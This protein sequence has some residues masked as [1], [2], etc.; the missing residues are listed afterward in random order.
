[1]L[2]PPNTNRARPGSFPSAAYVLRRIQ[3]NRQL[4]AILSILTLFILYKTNW[5]S[6]S[7]SSSYSALEAQAER[8]GYSYDAVNLEPHQKAL[9]RL[10]AKD[11]RDKND[12]GYPVLSPKALRDKQLERLLALGKEQN[13]RNLRGN[14]FSPSSKSHVNCPDYAHYSSSI[15]SPLSNGHLQLPFQRPTEQCRTFSADS[16]EK[17]I[18]DM[19]ARL[20]DPDLARLFENCFPNT[21][22]T[23]VLWH[24]NGSDPQSFIV[25][26]D[27]NALWLRDAH[28]Q[29][30]IYSPLAKSDP[31]IKKLI[32][33]LINT[34]SDFVLSHPYCNAFQPPPQSGIDFK[35][36]N[37]ND[38]VFPRVN[39]N[40]VFEC[41]YEID[42]LASFLAI[43]NLYYK[44]T[45]DSS[46]V[47]PSWL[48]ALSR[49]LRVLQE[50]ATPTFSQTGHKLPNYYVFR[51]NTNTGTETL[52]LAGAGNPVNGGTS[53]IRSAFRPSD[54][55]TIYQFF[56]P[57]NAFM[58]VE[59]KRT[60]KLLETLNHND[61]VKQLKSLGDEI[62]RGIYE[63]G[64]YQ[65]PVFGK[66]FAYEVD[67]FGS[68]SIMDDANTPSL[69][70]LPD[71]G[72][73]SNTDEIYQNTRRM[74]LSKEGNPY[75][76]KGQFFEGVG[77]PHIGT[78][79]AWPMSQLLAI[80]TSN[81]DTEIEAALELVK[82]ST[83]GLGLMHESVNVDLPH[84]FTRSW[85]AWCNSEFAK[86]VLDLA[87]RKP[88]LVF[89]KGAE[90]YVMGTG[91]KSGDV[92][93]SGSGNVAS[94]GAGSGNVLDSKAGKDKEVDSAVDKETVLKAG[95]DDNS[96]SENESKVGV[97]KPVKDT[98]ATRENTKG[99]M[100][101]VKEIKQD[102][103]GDAKATEAGSKQGVES[104]EEQNLEVGG[105]KDTS[106]SKGKNSVQSNKGKNEIKKKK[107]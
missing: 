102:V 9:P 36:N 107:K 27:I 7:S 35:F 74:I 42:S 25:T 61:L 62:E 59:L 15:H 19:N 93:G 79:F 38:A 46:F 6:S 88:H 70:S 85:F 105:N 82:G 2:P 26:G 51:R 20:T 80:R 106:N 17:V 54:D 68:I 63:H 95:S 24:H 92:V 40:I 44:D 90:P 4:V 57:G 34:Q 87:E 37:E 8:A 56:I 98:K 23:T 45:G 50:Q 73:V 66:V 55:A 76:L 101:D 67:G 77:G 96:G 104:Q 14:P 5:F 47:T 91:I 94:A 39:L 30:Q 43:G 65:H 28:K 100:E 60:A 18:G 103:K 32:L 81:N 64:T 69:L 83:S 29:V 13:D 86:T 84:S 11:Y 75:Y 99:A 89:G 41:K 52:N 78:R 48:N 72:F 71:M 58:S 33:G 22:D 31:K 12:Q 3:S 53:L 1:M 97:K 10:N 16:V 21:L 49:L